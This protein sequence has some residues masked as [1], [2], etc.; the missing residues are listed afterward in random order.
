[1]SRLPSTFFTGCITHAGPEKGDHMALFGGSGT[2]KQISPKEL[3][4]IIKEETGF[5]NPKVESSEKVQA[6]FLTFRVQ[7]YFYSGGE[8]IQFHWAAAGTKATMEKVNKWNKEKRFSC[9]Y[10]DE[11]GDP[12]LELD[13]DLE[14]G[15][16]EEAVRRFIKVSGVSLMSF[17][18][19]CI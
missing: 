8:S 1:M 3:C 2:I 6:E 4:R 5:D 13:L 12:H 7:F 15:V 19:E 16:T 10:L 14:G 18:T 11:D 17:M 9:A